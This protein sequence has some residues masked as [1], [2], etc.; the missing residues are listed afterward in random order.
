MGFERLSSL[1]ELLRSNPAVR[2]GN[3]RRD[4]AILMASVFQ[5]APPSMINVSALALSIDKL[6]VHEITGGAIRLVHD[7][8]L[9]SI[10]N[11]PPKLMQRSWI[12]ESADLDAP[13]WDDTVC[14]GGYELDSYYYLVGLRYPDGALVARWKPEWSSDNRDI[15][16]PI[17][18][19]PL[20][21]DAG[22]H[23]EWALNAVRFT[24]ILSLLLEAWDS[25]LETKTAEPGKRKR[26]ERAARARAWSVQRI[27]LSR[28]RAR[29]SRNDQSNS[30]LRHI[31]A[32]R[33]PQQTMVSGHLRRIRYGPGSS[34]VRWQW[35]TSY[36]AR[37]WAAPRV[38]YRVTE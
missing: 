32:D 31:A 38:R 29:R 13:L 9:R 8:D 25:P 7:A 12:V 23:R 20:I 2:T 18:Y 21:D 34:Q 1:V 6:A 37:R 33:H 4:A 14:L 22:G 19:S 10:P 30:S 24:L 36:E 5:D 28:P 17:D 15:Q 35:I 11:G 16:I 3:L 26:G 27:V